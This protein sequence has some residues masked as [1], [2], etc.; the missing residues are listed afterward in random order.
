M[1]AFDAIMG[2]VVVRVV[3]VELDGQGLDDANVVVAAFIPADDN[4]SLGVKC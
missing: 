1:G 2:T 3:N 4:G